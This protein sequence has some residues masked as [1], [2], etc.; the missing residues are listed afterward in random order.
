MTG[1]LRTDIHARAQEFFAKSLVEEISNADRAWLDVHLRACPDCAR[2]I[3]ATQNLL[4]ALRSVPVA[5]PRDLA[6]RTQLRVRLRA[7]ETSPASQSSGILLWLITGMS[8]L[9]GIFSA[10]VV[11]R[12]FAW[13]GSYFSIPKLALQVGFIFWWVVP[14]LFAVGAILHQKSLASASS[15]SQQ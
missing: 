6:A 2:E 12:A 13:V 10:P 8:W 15:R 14:A 9:L 7:Q 4:G 1:N 3:L 5:V 11:W